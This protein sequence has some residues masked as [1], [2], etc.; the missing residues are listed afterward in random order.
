MGLVLLHLCL[1]VLVLLRLLVLLY[2]VLALVLHL[3]VLVL[4]LVL[5]LLVLVLLHL[6]LLSQLGTYFFC[7]ETKLFLKWDHALLTS[8]SS[9]NWKCDSARLSFTKSALLKL[10]TNVLFSVIFVRA[11]ILVRSRR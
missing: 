2:L 10:G 11:L 8:G 3:F 5:H 6:L 1:L 4:V 9:G 7:C